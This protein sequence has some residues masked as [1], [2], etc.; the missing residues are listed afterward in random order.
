MVKHDI[1]NWTTQYVQVPDNNNIIDFVI[2]QKTIYS[3]IEKIG[4]VIYKIGDKFVSNVT[5]HL[6]NTLKLD[7]YINPFNGNEF[8]GILFKPTK[9]S[10]ELFMELLINHTKR[11]I[12]A[13]IN[14]DNSTIYPKMLLYSGHDVTISK[15]ELFKT[16]LA[17][18]Q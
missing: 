2:C 12:D 16:P 5:F 18:A 3:L 14:N 10:Y 4:L 11:S 17:P 7:H 8:V 13:D 6:N 9:E 1:N 15:Q